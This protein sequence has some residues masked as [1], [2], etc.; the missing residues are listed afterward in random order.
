MKDKEDHFRRIVTDYQDRIYRLCWSYVQDQE[1]RK[2]IY[3]SILIKIWNGIDSF[4]EK[5]SLSTWIYRLSVNASIDYIRKNK[6]HK[7]LDREVDL[8]NV[9]IADKTTDIEESIIVSENI[10][11]LH[12]FIRQLSFIDKTLIFFYLEDLKYFEIAE[13]LG[14]SEKNVSIKLHRIKSLLKQY[15]KDLENDN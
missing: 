4:Q 13:I 2:D 12:K 6:K 9:N 10:E 5:S 8:S 3:Q 7:I 1:D 14:I 15:F 11:N